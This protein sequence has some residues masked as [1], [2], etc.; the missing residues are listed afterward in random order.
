MGKVGGFLEI[1]RVEQPERDP[2][3]RSAGERSTGSSR[4]YSMNPVGFP[5]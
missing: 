1:T 3:T 4:R 2:R 5:I